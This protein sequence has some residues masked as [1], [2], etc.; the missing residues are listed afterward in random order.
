ML[1]SSKEEI[2]IIMIP[3]EVIEKIV[4]REPKEGIS[5]RGGKRHTNLQINLGAI[6]CSCSH[7]FAIDCN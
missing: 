5:I 3:N 4:L 7:I 1:K 2:L 6:Y